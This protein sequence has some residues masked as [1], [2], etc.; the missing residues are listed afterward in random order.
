MQGGAAGEASGLVLTVR[1]GQHV[2]LSTD[3][4][5]RMHWQQHAKI[6][7]VR[8]GSPAAGRGGAGTG[9]LHGGVLSRV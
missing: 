2:T 1:E 7:K 4:I 6:W 8:R 3:Q 5:R 9:L